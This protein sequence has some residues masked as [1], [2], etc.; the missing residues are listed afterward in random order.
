MP[1]ATLIGAL[2]ICAPGRVLRGQDETPALPSKRDAQVGEMRQIA[3]SLLVFRGAGSERR[4]LK[5]RGEPLLRWNDP[6]RRFSDASLW[7]WGETGRPVAVLTLEMSHHDRTDRVSWGLEFI[8]L[9]PPSLKLREEHGINAAVSKSNQLLNGSFIWA[10]EKPGVTFREIPDAPPPAESPRLRLGQM[11]DLIKRFVATEHVSRQPDLL[12]LMPHPIDRYAD[13]GKDQVDGAIFVFAH[14]T[15]P[16]VMV[17]IEAQGSSPEKATWR[18]AVARLTVAPF[19][20]TID[21]REVWTE[22][23]HS[24]SMN[25]PTLPYFTV[26]LP[27]R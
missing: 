14:G 18:F 21:R 11:R 16:E 1:L 15:N 5:L 13:Q 24:S 7:A 20:V 10:P 19:E 8:S 12:R 27:G 17:L 2:T 26:R 25:R 6:I 4:A 22:S 9:A 3:E 23:Y